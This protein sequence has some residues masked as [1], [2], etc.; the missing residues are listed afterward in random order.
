VNFAA[1]DLAAVVY[2]SGRGDA[3]QEFTGDRRLP[4]ASIDK[5][6]GRRLYRSRWR[7]RTSSFWHLMELQV[8]SASATDPDNNGQPVESGTVRGPIGFSTSRP[9]PTTSSAAIG[10]NKFLNALKTVAETM[11]MRD[12]GAPLFFSE[13]IDYPIYDVFGPGRH[14]CSGRHQGRDRRG[15]PLKP[16]LSR[17]IREDSSGFPPKSVRRLRRSRR[18]FDAHGLEEMR[19][20][21]DSLARWL[22]KKPGAGGGGSPEHPPVFDRIVHHERTICS[23]TIRRALG[24]RIS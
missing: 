12:A 11:G 19:L 17:S 8:N 3:S 18:G 13:G 5:F 15:G 20:S 16:Q 10:P 4:L 1:N 2:T 6:V 14:E 7:K 22:K 23:D 21:Q 9:T 24:R